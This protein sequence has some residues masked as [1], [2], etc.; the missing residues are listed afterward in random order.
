MLL[1]VPSISSLTRLTTSSQV[2][3]G[4]PLW[5]AA[6]SRGTHRRSVEITTTKTGRCAAIKIGASTATQP[7]RE[8][9]HARFFAKDGGGL[10][11]VVAFGPCDAVGPGK[12]VHDL[13]LEVEEG[14]LCFRVNGHLAFQEFEYRFGEGQICL[15]C[16]LF[17]N[18][19]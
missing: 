18:Q 12:A 3:A 15:G 16:T 8:D 7:A 2:V 13:R 6:S 1:K 5:G 17:L 9:G 14:T 4:G 19:G 11:P 10:G